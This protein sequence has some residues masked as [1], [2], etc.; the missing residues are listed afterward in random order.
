MENQKQNEM[1]VAVETE[2]GHTVWLPASQVAAFKAGQ[3]KFKQGQRPRKHM[4]TVL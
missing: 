3:Q 4:G 1:R 2:N